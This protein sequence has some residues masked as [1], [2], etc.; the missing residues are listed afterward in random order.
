[1]SGRAKAKLCGAGFYCRFALLHSSFFGLCFGDEHWV[2][3]YTQPNTP[4]ASSDK[5]FPEAVI[6]CTEKLKRWRRRVDRRTSE[7]LSNL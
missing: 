5:I 1:M 7:E 3:S 6:A 2:L 4:F